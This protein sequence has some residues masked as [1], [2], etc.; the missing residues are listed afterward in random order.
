MRR[1]RKSTRMENVPHPPDRRAH[2]I[3]TTTSEEDV[4]SEKGYVDVETS[5][6]SGV[7]CPTCGSNYHDLDWV[8]CDQC[9]SWY[10]KQ[11][12]NIPTEDY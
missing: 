1:G 2:K 4:I 11:C 8:C 9:N 6:D 3:S 10:H 12:T 7:T 5:S